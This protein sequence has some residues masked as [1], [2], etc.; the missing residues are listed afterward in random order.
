M[1]QCYLSESFGLRRI[2]CGRLAHGGMEWVI[3]HFNL[4]GSS[5]SLR[6]NGVDTVFVG[7][8]AILP[9]GHIYL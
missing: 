2:A 8:D 5:V 4:S 9:E 3:F 7:A 1:K 6:Q